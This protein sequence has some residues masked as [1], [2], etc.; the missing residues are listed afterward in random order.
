MKCPN[1]NYDSVG[2]ECFACGKVLNTPVHE[3]SKIKIRTKDRAAD[4]REY[5]KQNKIFLEKNTR[6]AV[7]PQLRATQVHHKKGRRGKLLL[8]QRYWIAV[9]DEGHTKIHDFPV[10]A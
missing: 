6:C 7:F 9:S 2:N 5:L 3:K 1:C 8:D 4:E 10:W